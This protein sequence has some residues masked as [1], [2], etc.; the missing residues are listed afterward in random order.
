METKIAVPYFR[1]IIHLAIKKH[2][3]NKI[4]NNSPP[5][6]QDSLVLFVFIAVLYFHISYI[7]YGTRNGF[8]MCMLSYNTDT[9]S[10]IVV[11]ITTKGSVLLDSYYANTIQD[12]SI[13]EEDLVFLSMEYTYNQR[14]QPRSRNTVSLP[15]KSNSECKL[16]F[17]KQLIT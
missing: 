15:Q 1:S 17:N 16:R 9:L 10:F 6:L 7:Q 5:H 14:E 3:N 8:K 12:R 11:F 4:F 2:M 13:W